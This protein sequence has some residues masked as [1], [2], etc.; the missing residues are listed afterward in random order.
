VTDATNVVLVVM[1]TTRMRD[2]DPETAPTLH[3]LAAAG[4][5]YRNAFANAPW[6]LP[7]HASLF[8]GLYPSEHRATGETHWLPENRRLVQAVLRDAGYRTAAVSNNTWITEEFGFDR[9]FDLLQRGW[10]LSGVAADHGDRSPDVP[11]GVGSGGDADSSTRAGDDGARAS[12]EWIDSW[13]DGVDDPFFLFANFIEPHVAY[14]PPSEFAAPFLPAGWSYEDATA[15]RQDPR[16]YDADEYDLSEGE[17]AALRGLYRGEIAYLDERLD[18]LRRTLLR[19]G[20][21]DDTVFVVVGDH[22]EHVGDHGFFGHQYCLSDASLRVP[23]VLRGGAFDGGPTWSPELVELRDLAPTL[24]DVAGVDGGVR[25]AF[26]G[27]SLHPSADAAA[28]RFAVSEYL[29]PQPSPARLADRFGDL[30]R[31]VRRYDRSIRTVRSGKYRYVSRS[32][33]TEALF[34]APPP[35]RPADEAGRRGPTERTDVGARQPDALTRHR[36]K[37]R[38]RTRADFRSGANDDDGGGGR[39][40]RD[41]RGRREMSEEASERLRDLGYL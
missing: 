25:E 35:G 2:V 38:D 34:E 22:G 20:R 8:T 16:R 17:L 12:V 11:S 39:D 41:G 3:E 21:W 32:D 36:A 14:E 30:P 10:E 28:R 6:T 31:H 33:G 29:D 13:L 19:R 40:G 1:D 37:L 27:R 18:A 7:S 15:I 9:G 5:G 26:G 24:L 4:T 23:L